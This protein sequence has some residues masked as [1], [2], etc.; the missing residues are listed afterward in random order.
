MGPELCFVSEFIEDCGGGDRTYRIEP[1][2]CTLSTLPNR[3]LLA[4]DAA[5]STRLPIVD[6]FELF[7]SAVKFGVL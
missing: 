3:A 4:R 5:E 2:L 1:L 6:D 7:L